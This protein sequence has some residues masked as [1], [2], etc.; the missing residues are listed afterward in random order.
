MRHKKNDWLQND[1]LPCAGSR[2]GCRCAITPPR[3]LRFSLHFRRI[4]VRGFLI[5]GVNHPIVFRI[6]RA[7]LAIHVLGRHGEHEAFV[8]RAF[9]ARPEPTV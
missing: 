5:V 3:S 1:G 7:V 9:V 8:I 2:G 6:K 4:Q